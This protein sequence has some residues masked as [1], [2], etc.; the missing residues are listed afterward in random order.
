MMQA[1][2]IRTGDRCDVHDDRGRVIGGWTADGDAAEIVL[3][4]GQRKV[5]FPVTTHDGQEHTAVFDYD[6]QVSLTF[7]YGDPMPRFPQG[8]PEY[9]AYAAELRA[10][11]AK[12]VAQEPP[13][14]KLPDGSTPGAARAAGFGL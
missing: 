6:E 13:Y 9:D 4:D 2:G 8:T 10:E 1:Q 14:D 3:E 7:G 5:A 12:F 11:L